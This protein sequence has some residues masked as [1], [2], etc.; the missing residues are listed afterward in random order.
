MTREQLLRRLEKVERE[1]ADFK[2]FD[3]LPFGA[4]RAMTRRI[5]KNLDQQPIR[6]SAKTTNSEDV[7]VVTGVNFGAQSTTTTAVLNDPNG[8]LE[9]ELGGVMYYLPFFT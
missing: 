5:T 4:D 2:R 3:R 1:L 6:L 8:F 9:I 7:T